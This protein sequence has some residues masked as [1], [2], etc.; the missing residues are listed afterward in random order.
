ME[1]K[2]A[3][4]KVRLTPC[5]SYD[6]AATE[7]WLQ[8]MAEDGWMLAPESIFGIWAT[9]VERD[10]GDTCPVRYRLDAA[11]EPTG[12]I[13]GS[14]R[15]DEEKVAAFHEMGW[16]YVTFHG[17]FYVY[18]SFDPEAEEL[19]TDPAVQALALKKV[20]SRMK[21]QLGTL[22]FW[23]VIYPLFG[24]FGNLWMAALTIGTGFFLIF[25]LS[26]LLSVAG[27]LRGILQ[28]RKVKKQLQAGQPLTRPA[29]PEKKKRR[30]RIYWVADLLLTV[31]WIGMAVG[32]GMA[33][34]DGAFTHPLGEYLN[35]IRVPTMTSLSAEGQV[36]YDDWMDRGNGTVEVHR[37]WLL[38]SFYSITENGT[39][40]MP[41]G[42]EFNGG[43]YVDYIETTSPW[44]ARQMAREYVRFDKWKNFWDYLWGNSRYTDLSLPDLGVDYAAAY[45]EYFPT[46]VLAE[47]NQVVHLYFYDV[48]DSVNYLD[49]AQIY[50]DALKGQQPQ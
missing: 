34:L 18:R 14:S 38:G 24:L 12:W 23:M 27:N 30:Y 17:E 31:L 25:T 6:I 40:L 1:T 10:P 37:D 39:F 36:E 7:S 47:G 45:T 20:G 22:I 35:E 13:F 50:A 5:P 44:V 16:E 3:K 11:Q 19:N 2:R 49:L 28:L 41:D 21:S 46:V 42:T 26:F 8:R 43:L 33:D 4:K 29:N 48:N 9:F 32:Y 15:P